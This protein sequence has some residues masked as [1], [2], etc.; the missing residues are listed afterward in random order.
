[1]VS[2]LNSVEGCFVGDACFYVDCRRQG[3]VG[4]VLS[5]RQSFYSGL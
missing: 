3:Y 2:Q 4:K 5:Q 1:M